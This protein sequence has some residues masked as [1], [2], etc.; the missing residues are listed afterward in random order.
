MRRAARGPGVSWL[1]ALLACPRCRRGLRSDGRGPNGVQLC[2]RC[3]PYPRLAGVPVLV[4][5][6]HVW[7]ASFREA[8]LASLAEVGAATEDAVA[9]VD[10]FAAAAPH[11]EPRRFGD[12]WT[13]GE[14]R[15]SARAPGEAERPLEDAS[16]AASTAEAGRRT[17]RAQAKSERTR[18][19]EDLTTGEALRTARAQAAAE[20]TRRSDDLTSGEALRSARAQAAAERTRRSE[21]LTSGEALRGARAQAAAEQGLGEASTTEDG[22][23]ASD[24]LAAVLV[25][26]RT[27]GPA[28][29]VQRHVPRG[30][31]VV[32]VGCGAGVTGAALARRAERLVVA[33]V[34]LRAVLRAR[35][36]GVAAGGEVAGVVLEAEALPL[37]SRAV[38]VLVAEHLVDL[39]D[40][41]AD[42]LREAR[43]VLSRD[44]RAL[45]TTPEP[46]LGGGDDEALAQLAL[47]AGFRV[48]ARV[49]GLTWVRAHSPRFVEVYAVQALAL[50]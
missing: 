26:A 4:Q 28:A 16:T 7:C 2:G 25:A 38:D 32:E 11:A 27:A 22:R 33:D 6:P 29:W 18:R 19:S 47:D 30:G 41:P 24:A 9:V 44:G 35:S 37:A 1:D 15:E 40:A 50:R 3:G 34:S 23:M 14:G 42:F 46:S 17:A 48:S 39:L 13:A 10:A 49:D 45:L 21:D 5:E 36:R 8:A 43:R 20:R 12:D 31:V